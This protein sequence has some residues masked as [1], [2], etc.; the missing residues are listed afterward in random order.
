MV[1]FVRGFRRIGWVATIPIAAFLILIF[2]ETT[3]EF[4]AI[5]YEVRRVYDS[6]LPDDYTL[7]ELPRFGRAHFLTDV[8]ADVQKR[9][10]ADFSTAEPKLI[11]PNSLDALQDRGWRVIENESPKVEEWEF[12]VQKRIN[13]PRLFGLVVA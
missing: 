6:F 2:F 1:N 10:A 3:K 8:P 9:I 11:N 5:G 13:A 12:T 7:I 4:S